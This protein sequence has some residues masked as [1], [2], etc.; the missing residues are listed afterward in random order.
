MEK[1]NNNVDKRKSKSSSQQK[2]QEGSLETFHLMSQST[3][4]K[5]IEETVTSQISPIASQVQTPS[6]V[7]NNLPEETTTLPT[8]NATLSKTTTLLSSR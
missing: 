7:C 2:A 6:K 4:D 5:Y 8:P 1:K 3:T